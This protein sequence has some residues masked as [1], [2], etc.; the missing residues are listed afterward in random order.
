MSRQGVSLLCP[1][2]P[3]TDS[4]ALL[5]DF[6]VAHLSSDTTVFLEYYTT[7]F[8]VAFTLAQHQPHRAHT[9][10]RAGPQPRKFI[11]GF[12]FIAPAMP[13]S[14]AAAPMQAAAAPRA[15]GEGAVA[16]QTGPRAPEIDAQAARAKTV[17]NVSDRQWSREMEGRG[18]RGER[19]SKEEEG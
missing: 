2:L 1:R 4:S 6:A 13:V 3:C 11:A 10:A 18:G 16:N 8:P 12:R 17:Q 19:R 15:W 9:A 14:L 5:P 7:L